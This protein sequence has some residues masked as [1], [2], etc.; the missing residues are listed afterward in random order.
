MAIDAYLKIPNV[1]GEVTNPNFKDQIALSS[2]SWGG[3]QASSMGTASGGSGAG[4]VTMHPLSV[5]KQVDKATPSLLHA[6]CT[7]AHFDTVTLS[8]V[9]AGATKAYLVVE[10]KRV[11]V[12]TL[13]FSGSDDIPVESVSM[14]Y[15]AITI[16]YS[17]QDDKG[18]LTSTGKKGYNVQTGQSI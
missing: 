13:Q 8:A 16:D 12:S 7:G 1:T 4:K 9:K 6:M 5:T 14:T 3:E 10:I 17:Q 11:F 15:G 2:F 18:T